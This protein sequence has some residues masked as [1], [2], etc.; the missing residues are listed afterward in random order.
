AFSLTTTSLSLGIV[1]H[2][3]TKAETSDNESEA[4][5]SQNPI[6]ENATMGPGYY[7]ISR[8]RSAFSS[9]AATD[10]AGFINTVAPGAISGWNKYGILPSVSIAQGI[11]E[12]GWGK[13]QLATTG[14]NLFGIKGVYQG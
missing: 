5:V 2:N 6:A 10:T 13:S 12:S 11:L 8:A 1:N 4:V 3:F 7:D 14:N 9:R